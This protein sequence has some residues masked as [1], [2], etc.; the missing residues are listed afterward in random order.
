MNS[1]IVQLAESLLLYRKLVRQAIQTGGENAL[2]DNNIPAA[3]RVW[4]T[5]EMERVDPGLLSGRLLLA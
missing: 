5:H 2:M 1:S 3:L 4:I